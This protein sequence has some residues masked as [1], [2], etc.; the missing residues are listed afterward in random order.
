MSCIRYR[1][2]FYSLTDPTCEL[3]SPRDP[4]LFSPVT[5]DTFFLAM[6]NVIEANITILCVCL[7]ASKP[8]F[9]LLTP[10]KLISSMGS[11]FTRS[12]ETARSKKRT[13]L[14]STAD[15]KD[16]SSEAHLPPN[17][18]AFEL[19]Y[20]PDFLRDKDM[21]MFCTTNNNSQW[22][23]HPERPNLTV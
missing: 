8:V 3:I 6:W 12:F 7:I 2:T 19:Q 9:V 20:N 11:F 13:P 4:I 15:R 21:K 22:P 10:N 14:D 16:S 18:D 5:G 1:Y 23:G 17:C